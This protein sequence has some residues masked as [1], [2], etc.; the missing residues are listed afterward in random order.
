MC[1]I[2]PSQQYVSILQMNDSALTN[3]QLDTLHRLL[4]QRRDSL[5]TQLVQ[6]ESAAEPVTL[7]Q[8]SVGRVSRVDAIQQQQMAIAN[9]TQTAQQ[10]HRTER[11]LQRVEDGIYGDC[12]HCGEPIAFTR[13]EVQPEASLCLACQ[14]VS[15]SR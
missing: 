10:L 6:F 3:K 11:A 9:K 7:D 12:L 4:G 1:W 14:S 8:Q 15:E 13:L 2:A 5:K